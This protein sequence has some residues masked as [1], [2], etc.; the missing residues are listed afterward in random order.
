[1]A[2]I[3]SFCSSIKEIDD[4]N[5]TLPKKGQKI[6]PTE[7]F[8]VRQGGRNVVIAKTKDGTLYRFCEDGLH[9]GS[10]RQ[11]CLSMSAHTIKEYIAPLV[12]AGLIS[13]AALEE[14]KKRVERHEML[15]TKRTAAKAVL[16]HAPSV[17]TLTVK[18]KRILEEVAIYGRSPAPKPKTK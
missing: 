14:A 8:Q 6:I 10:Q 9:R 5:L 12:A 1:M 4:F 15:D 18:Q 3:V 16:R 13:K 17:I 7:L 11:A 2:Q